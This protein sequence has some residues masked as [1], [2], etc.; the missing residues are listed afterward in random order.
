M[1][2]LSTCQ[3]EGDDIKIKKDKVSGYVQK[4][5]FING[6]SILMSELN[7]SMV[8]TGKIFTA[9]IINN[10]GSFEINNISLASS[11]VEFSANG[12]YFNEVQGDLSPATLNLYALSD[13]TDILT[14]NINILTHLEKQRVAYLVK[15]NKSFSEA[16]NIA[17]GEILAIFGFSLNE[18]DNSEELDISVNNESNAILLAISIILQGNRSVSDL[19]ELLATITNDIRE[20]GILNSESIMLSLR[21]STKELNLSTIRSSLVNRYQNLGISATI[22]GFEKYINDFLVFTGQKPITTTQAATNITTTSV[23]LNAVVNANSLSTAVI[24]EYGKTINYGD[25]INAT[26]SPVTGSSSVSVS[27]ALTELLPGTTYHFRVKTK[28]SL[29]ITYGSDLTFT[30]LGQLPSATTQEATDITTVSVIL[31]GTVNANLL[32]T[33]VMFEW[34]KTITYSDS[35]TATQSP[36]SGSTPF[37]VSSE[38]TELSPGTLYHFRIKT[39]N[40]LGTVYG[41]DLTFTTLGGVPTA[42]TQAATSIIRSGAI[43][44]GMV[45]ANDLTTTVTFEYGTTETYGSTID[46]TPNTVIGHTNTIVNVALTGLNPETTYHFRVKSVNSLGTTYG[47]DMTFLTILQTTINVKVEVAEDD[48]EEYREDYLYDPAGF[49]DIVSTDLELCTQ[50]ANN[51]QYVGIIWRNVTIPA[52]ATIISAFVQFTCDDNDNQEGPLPVDIV[53]IKEVNTSAPFTSDL[54]NISSRPVTS[55]KVTWDIPV[56]ATIEERGPDQ[57]TTDIKTIIQEIIDQAGWASGNNLGIRIS[58]EVMEKIHREASSF[59][60]ML[61]GIQGPEL[62]VTYM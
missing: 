53:G 51:R 60:D 16:K 35:I 21:N 28:N 20:D 46:A 47:S 62:I 32:S 5:P 58:N 15:Q 12:Y 1:L 13:L 30:S 3:K 10:S 43:L 59:E 11:Y 14:V 27:T 49:M 6:T 33:T 57:K 8:Q 61:P 42:S 29:G 31:K 25:T 19:T 44:N 22:P 55:A 4:G 48:A 50:N 26:Q 54:F 23:T 7:S 39:K 24:F 17:Q 38:I 41:S 37:N 56:W 9:Q 34:G 36:V 40:A 52:G 2:L 45:N 18:M